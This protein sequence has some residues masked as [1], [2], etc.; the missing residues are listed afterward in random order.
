MGRKRLAANGARSTMDETHTRMLVR[1][2]MQTEYVT[3]TP[4]MS[5]REAAA[6]LLARRLSS[7]PVLEGGK[8]IGILSEK[9][10]FRGLFPSYGDWMDGPHGVVDFEA[11]EPRMDAL[12]T[13]T[14]KDVMSHRVITAQADAPVLKIGALMASS[15]IHH[16]PVLDGTNLVGMV[17]RGSIYR[18]ILGKSFGIAV[19]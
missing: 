12:K 10:L 17:N 15:G 5:W 8:V 9:D 13:R 3:V 16:V 11:M 2:I 7:A 6:L 14:V 18:A 19:E 1:D 4:A